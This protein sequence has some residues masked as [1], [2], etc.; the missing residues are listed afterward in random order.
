MSKDNSQ[1]IVSLTK[2]VEKLQT[3]LLFPSTRHTAGR[4]EE[5]KRWVQRDIER[6]KK[7]IEQLK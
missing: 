6:T 2:Y 1:K 4:V 3:Q 7:R 5:F